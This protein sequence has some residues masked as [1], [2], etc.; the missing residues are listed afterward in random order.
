[1][2]WPSCEKK[3]P[4]PRDPLL[5]EAFHFSSAQI[6]CP[7]SLPKLTVKRF[8]KN[9]LGVPR[10][11]CIAVRTSSTDYSNIHQSVRQSLSLARARSIF[12]FLVSASCRE[13]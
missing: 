9:G 12:P 13:H 10:L 3:V 8:N 2:S 7:D 11:M 4:S 5:K 1:M 6:S